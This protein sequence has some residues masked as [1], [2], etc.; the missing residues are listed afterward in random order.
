MMVKN[1]GDLSYPRALLRDGRS[2]GVGRSINNSV[3]RSVDHSVGRSVS[4]SFGLSVGQP[5]G[6]SVWNNACDDDVFGSE[7]RII[8]AS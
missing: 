4:R 8:E 3:I 6:R 7:V 1:W 2:V 5:I